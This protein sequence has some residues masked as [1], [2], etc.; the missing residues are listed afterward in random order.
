MVVAQDANDD[1]VFRC[2]FESDTWYKEWGLSQAPARV[3]T[4][5]ADAERKFTPH[6]GKALR[7]RVDEG[8][9]YGA[10][11]QFRFKDQLGYE[12]EEVYFRYY[13]RLADDWSPKRGGK[14]PGFGGTYGRAGWGGRPVHGDDGWSSRGHFAGQEDGRTPFGF[15]CYH[16][17]MVGQYGSGWDWDIEQRGRLENNRWYCIEQYVR[18]NTPG[19]TDG[20]L[21]T[22]IDGR[23]AFRKQDIRFRST[24]KLKVECVWVNVYLGGK[25][26]SESTHHLYIDDVA[27][28][29]SRIGCED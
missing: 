11:V 24:D 16:M 26:V 19:K 18:L 20:V 17:D 22:W 10:S 12:P 21:A 25:W 15:Y 27:I 2:D 7:I 8:G 28:S 9:H 4:V 13:I 23:P 3:A 6:D 29:K 5:G 14:M 1:V